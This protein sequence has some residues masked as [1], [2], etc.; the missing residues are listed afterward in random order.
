MEEKCSSYN[1]DGKCILCLVRGREGE[2]ALRRPGPRQ[3]GN[4]KM[5]Q[6]EVGLRSGW[7]DLS[8]LGQVA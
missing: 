6:Q 5:D 1:G 4:I 8:L 2:A 7:G 3:D